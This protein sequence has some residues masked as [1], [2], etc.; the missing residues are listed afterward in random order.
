MFV[1]YS[2]DIAVTIRVVYQ[3]LSVFLQTFVLPGKSVSAV[4]FV[5]C[6]VLTVRVQLKK[7]GAKKGAWAVVTGAT[8]GI[9]KEFALQLAKAGFNVF[10][11]ARNTSLLSSVGAEIGEYFDDAPN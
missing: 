6:R 5:R 9:G 4:S 8:D 10:L 1:T 2:V 7:F 3:T 11:V